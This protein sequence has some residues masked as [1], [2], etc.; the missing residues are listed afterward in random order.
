MVPIK[1]KV[2]TETVTSGRHAGPPRCEPD[3]L[4][5]ER[6]WRSFPSRRAPPSERVRRSFS[7]RL[8]ADPP[9]VCAVLPV[10]ADTTEREG[11]AVLPG[12]DS[13]GEDELADLVTRD[14]M[15]GV[16]EV[17]GVG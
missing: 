3:D 2:A 13:L 4:T 5:S 10:E 11:A 14:A 8:E 16:A 15:I 1:L 7:L 6:V 12:T 17:A 9:L